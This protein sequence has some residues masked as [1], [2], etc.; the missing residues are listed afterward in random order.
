MRVKKD[1]QKQGSA[2]SEDQPSLYGG[3]QFGVLYSPMEDS[4]EAIS[5]APD[6]DKQT[7]QYSV[8]LNRCYRTYSSRGNICY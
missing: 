6:Q 5:V 3:R 2:S 7:A 1:E 4:S 8:D